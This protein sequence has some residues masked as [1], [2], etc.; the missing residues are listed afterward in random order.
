MHSTQ[1]FKEGRSVSLKFLEVS[2]RLRGDR[3]QETFP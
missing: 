1:K 2:Q 3:R